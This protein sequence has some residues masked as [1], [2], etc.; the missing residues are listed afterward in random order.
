MELILRLELEQ[1]NQHPTSSPT[2]P[3]KEKKKVTF[4]LPQQSRI[5]RDT[6]W[7]SKKIVFSPVK[8]LSL[9]VQSWLILGPIQ[10][11]LCLTTLTGQR[12]IYYKRGSGLFSTEL[13]WLFK[14]LHIH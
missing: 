1:Y 3:K 9:I 13:V 10:P 8:D 6:F 2:A 14:L 4:Y 7:E 5:S 11:P 12:H